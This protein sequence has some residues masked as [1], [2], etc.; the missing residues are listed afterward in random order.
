MHFSRDSNNNLK[1][2]EKFRHL[3]GLKHVNI[4]FVLSVHFKMSGR[5]RGV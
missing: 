5:T 3:Y 2:E 4:A 1:I